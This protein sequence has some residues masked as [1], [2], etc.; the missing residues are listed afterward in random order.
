MDHLA[1]MDPKTKFLDQILS[2]SKT[3]E[4]RW[5]LHRRSPWEKVALGDTIYFKPSGKPVTAKAL[6]CEVRYFSELNPERVLAILNRYQSELGLAA[7]KQSFFEA[8]KN[9]K[10]AILI[11]I[12]DLKK[13][14]PFLISKHGFG[15]QSAWLTVPDINMIKSFQK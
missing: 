5:Y 15:S 11:S 3:I 6:V 13:V 7:N 4:S 8:V 2:G 12:C 1:I 9:K 14:T 10:Y